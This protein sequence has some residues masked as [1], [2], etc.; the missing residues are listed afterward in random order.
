M[1]KSSP[2]LAAGSRPPAGIDPRGPRVSAAVTAVLLLAV[3][4]LAL[5]GNS[6]SG[7]LPE[8]SFGERASAPA[9]LL[10]LVVAIL[11]GWSLVSA[12]TQ[13]LG[14]LFRSLVQPRLAPPRE[15]EDPRPP[16]FAQGV[17]LVVVSV[18]L[19][20]QLLGIPWGLPAAAAA[21]FIAAFLNAAIGLCLGCELYLLLARLRGGGAGAGAAERRV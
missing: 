19:A 10:L 12:R 3:I 21:A 8:L 20:L 9:T 5:T 4:Y 13:P 6:V 1:T 7:T 17:G 15:W 11:F 14:V 2:D 18:G 16:R